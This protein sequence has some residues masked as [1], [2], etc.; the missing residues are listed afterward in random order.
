VGAVRPRFGTWLIDHL[1][2]IQRQSPPPARR[3]RF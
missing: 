1:C 2:G 3:A